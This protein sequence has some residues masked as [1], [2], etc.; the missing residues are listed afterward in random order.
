VRFLRN[1]QYVHRVHVIFHADISNFFPMFFNTFGT[2]S[3][4]K[5][6]NCFLVLWKKKYIFSWK[7]YKH[8]CKIYY[9]TEILSCRHHRKV[10]PI[11]L[12]Y[13]QMC[14]LYQK[15]ILCYLL[16][17]NIWSRCAYLSSNDVFFFVEQY[18]RIFLYV[19]TYLQADTWFFRVKF[20]LYKHL[21]EEIY[22]ML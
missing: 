18:A 2:Y 9:K 8:M 16:K 17:H 1:I 14:V 13:R 22:D 21:K 6:N 20:A 12:L 10:T 3:N 19:R 11:D 7:M 5:L 15:Y 4:F